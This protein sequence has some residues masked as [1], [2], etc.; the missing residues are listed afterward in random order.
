MALIS[1][2]GPSPA[3]PARDGTLATSG[4]DARHTFRRS[5]SRLPAGALRLMAERR[6]ME[7]E[8]EAEDAAAMAAELVDQLDDPA[9]ASAIRERLDDDERL[10]VGLFGLTEN[11]R[12]PACGLEHALSALGAPAAKVVDGLLD[13]G[14]LA[15]ATDVPPTEL[16]TPQRVV[17]SA[18]VDLLIHPALA[19]GSRIRPPTTPA[20]PVCEAV[21]QIREFDGLEPILRLAALWQRLG[22]EPAR[23]TQT[24]ALYKRDRERLEEDAVISGPFRDALVDAPDAGGLLMELA[25]RIGLIRLDQ[26]REILMAS[27]ADF[28]T[29]NDVHLPQMI[30]SAWLGL[31]SWREWSEPEPIEAARVIGEPIIYLRPALLLWLA[32]LEPEDWVTLDDLAEHLTS[33]FPDWDRPSFEV[34]P[35]ERDSSRRSSKGGAKRERRP[36][37]EDQARQALERVLLGGACA[38]GLVRAAD[39][40]STGRGAVQLTALGRYVM[41]VGP[42]PGAPPSFEKFLFAQPN[43]DVIAYRQGL[44]PPLIGRLSQFAWWTK[45]DAA[46]ELRLTRES[47]AGGLEWGMTVARMMEILTHHGQRPPPSAV[48]DAVE[49]WAKHRE[50]VVFY[51]AATLIEFDSRRER[52]RAVEQWTKADVTGEGRPFIPV[53]ERLIL[54]EDARDVPTGRIS[55]TAARDYR[56]PPE[57]CVAVEP[58]G[59]TLILDPTRSDLLIDAELARFADEAPGDAPGRVDPLRPAERRFVVTPASLRRGLE[60]GLTPALLANWFERRAGVEPPPALKLMARPTQPKERPWRAS[61]RLVLDVPSA[62]LLD[63]VLQHPL[64]RPWLG[65]RLGPVSVEVSEENVDQLRAALSELG[66][67]VEIS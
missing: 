9:A 24:G 20:L 60:L 48:K 61:R 52:D 31:R 15:V 1:G 3:H 50:R 30:A 28:W 13:R 54:V 7:L 39:E 64:T 43:L 66:V 32:G 10:A 6:G 42:P 40:E 63:G 56:L 45:I 47:I 26:S 19:S 17:A 4:G 5:L 33:I 58:D 46:I 59:V 38:M 21:V 25:K 35:A 51:E 36:S 49:R 34:E 53:G 23:L 37:R 8:A 12:W 11:P 2:S 18:D 55:T 27:S 44:T 65:D 62:E 22:A 16:L 57:R 67:A 29:E 14:L 41:R